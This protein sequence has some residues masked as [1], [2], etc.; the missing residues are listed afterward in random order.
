[1]PSIEWSIDLGGVIMAVI[2]L[3]FIPIAR[4]LIST[5]WSVREAVTELTVAVFG[6]EKDRSIGIV[7]H[8]AELKKES[9]KHRNWLIQLSADSGSKIEDRP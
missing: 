4:S 1:M 3:V 9:M 6:T 8:L 5:L 2:A 7:A